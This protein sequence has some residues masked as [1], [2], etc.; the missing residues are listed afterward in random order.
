MTWTTQQKK[1]AVIQTGLYECHD[2]YFIAYKGIRWNRY[3]AFN[4]QYPYLPGETYTT[5]A[6]YTEEEGSFG[7]SA[8][9]E[10]EAREYCNELVI[11]VKIY[12]EDVARVV[13][14]GGKIRC[15]RMTVLT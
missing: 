5:H 3:S 15:C 12:Y 10:E 1:E 4:F 13:H 2:E 14:N 7:F 8:W 9:T 6:D 11:K